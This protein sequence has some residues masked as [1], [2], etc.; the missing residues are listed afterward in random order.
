MRITKV[1]V[2]LALFIIATGAAAETKDAETK[3]MVQTQAQPLVIYSSQGRMELSNPSLCRQTRTENGSLAINCTSQ[4][5]QSV[6]SKDGKTLI[7]C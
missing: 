3:P 4:C 6:D 5:K 1:Q 2:A 7:Q